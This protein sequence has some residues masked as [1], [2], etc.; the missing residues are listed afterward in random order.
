MPSTAS[1][2][3]RI[4]LWRLISAKGRR[5]TAAPEWWTLPPQ[6]N[7]DQLAAN[8][9]ALLTEFALPEFERLGKRRAIVE[10][11]VRDPAS[12]WFGP[13]RMVLAALMAEAGRD[14]EAIEVA[15]NEVTD[16]AGRPNEEWAKAVA[17][18]LSVEPMTGQLV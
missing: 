11:W 10:A 18:R 6:K 12:P 14:V 8:I 3:L 1:C 15:A 13:S 7:L 2:Q 16:A 9:G 4:R 17:R 5:W